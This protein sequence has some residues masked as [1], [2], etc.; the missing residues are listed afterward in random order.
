MLGELNQPGLFGPT[1]PYSAAFLPSRSKFSF[2]RLPMPTAA[3]RC[4]L[5]VFREAMKS[6]TRVY[7]SWIANSR[8]EEIFKKHGSLT[9]ISVWHA[10]LRT[11]AI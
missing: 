11:C 6:R 10:A 2:V 5:I 1:A 9:P 7:Y 3:D 4:G 8:I